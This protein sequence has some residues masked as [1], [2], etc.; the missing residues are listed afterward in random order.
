M[1]LSLKRL[2]S[3]RR[4]SSVVFVYIL[5]PTQEP[6]EDSPVLNYEL[7]LI[8]RLKFEPKLLRLEHNIII[9]PLG[10]GGIRGW[11]FNMKI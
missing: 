7:D 5:N 10:Q 1:D 4:A 3:L 6:A 9:R 11:E 2:S 8:L